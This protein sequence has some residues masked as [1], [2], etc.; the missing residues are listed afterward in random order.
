MGAELL[1]KSIVDAPASLKLEKLT[2]Q[3]SK[4]EAKLT[5]KAKEGGCNSPNPTY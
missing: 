1:K 2:E 5:T 3:I 4:F